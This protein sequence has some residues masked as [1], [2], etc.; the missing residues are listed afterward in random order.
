MPLSITITSV[1]LDG[2]EVRMSSQACLAERGSHRFSTQLEC[3]H[4]GFENT[5]R[6]VPLKG[7]ELFFHSFFSSFISFRA[8]V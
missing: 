7:S 6:E 1:E 4:S 5:K 2:H 8:A 3:L